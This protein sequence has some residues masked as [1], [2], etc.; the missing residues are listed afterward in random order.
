MKTVLEIH[1]L[2]KQFGQQAILQDLSLT[3]KEG[4]IYGLIGKNGAGKTTLIKIITQLLF[5]DKGTVSLFSSQE[6]NEW[7]KAFCYRIT[8]SSQSLDSIPESEI[9]LYD[10]SYSKC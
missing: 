8:C 7:T 6:Q 3:I 5:A 2:T 1:G 9:L 4:D 10:T